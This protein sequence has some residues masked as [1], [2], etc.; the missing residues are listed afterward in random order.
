M[1]SVEPTISDEAVEAKTG[2]NW[3]EWFSILDSAGAQEMSHK[4]IV[5]YLSEQHQVGP[6]WQQAVTVAYEQARGLRDR[7]EMPSGYQISRSKTIPVSMDR[8]FTAWQDEKRRASWLPDPGFAIRKVTP[9]KS[10]RV[11]WE[12]GSTSLDIHFYEKGPG[13]SQVTVQHNK[14]ED[15][16]QADQMKAYW[17]DALDRLNQYLNQEDG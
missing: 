9:N 4:Q 8:L 17:S 2:K 5:A 14:L 6:W 15:A 16:Q 12:D 10:M 11:D 3:A 1:S 13:K 7:H